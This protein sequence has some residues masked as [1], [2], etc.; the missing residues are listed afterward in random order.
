MK[1]ISEFSDVK[2]VRGRNKGNPSPVLPK[3][4][5]PQIVHGRTRID[6][7]RS[8]FVRDGIPECNVCGISVIWALD[9]I[10]IDQDTWDGLDIFHAVGLPGT[11]LVSENFFEFVMEHKFTNIV[12][13]PAEEYR[14]CWV[15]ES[16]RR[17]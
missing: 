11:I 4:F 2:V 8:K 17:E 1:G 13:E 12:L 5:L 10:H 6:E 7:E 3:Y 16:K 9:S 14:P 15:L